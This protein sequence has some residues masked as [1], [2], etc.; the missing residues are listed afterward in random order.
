MRHELEREQHRHQ[1]KGAPRHTHKEGLA[2]TREARKERDSQEERR[3][4]T[5][6]RTDSAIHSG[7]QK[8]AHP[9]IRTGTDAET[10]TYTQ[11]REVQRQAQTH[12]HRQRDRNRQ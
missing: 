12:T 10:N 3:A 2:P 8:E 7:T 11:T 1:E 5:H 4:D 9:Y 6:P